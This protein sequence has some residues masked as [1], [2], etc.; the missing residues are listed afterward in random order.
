MLKKEI[1]VRVY[2]VISPIKGEFTVSEL[3]KCHPG[4]RDGILKHL[5]QAKNAAFLVWLQAFFLSRNFLES[6]FLSEYIG[7]QEVE[8]IFRSCDISSPPDPLKP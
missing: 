4:C 3:L 1:F 6:Q 2:K 5:Q 8:G 7:G